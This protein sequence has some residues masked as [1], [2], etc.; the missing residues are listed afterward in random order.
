MEIATIM[1]FL[2]CVLS[3]LKIALAIVQLMHTK[4]SRG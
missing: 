3:I 1:L 2:S 4:R